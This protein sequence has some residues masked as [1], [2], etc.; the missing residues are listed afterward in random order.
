MNGFTTKSLAP[1]SSAPTM[2]R[3]CLPGGQHHHREIGGGGLLANAAEDF[4]PIDHGHHRVEHHGV[5]LVRGEAFQRLAAVPRRRHLIAPGAQP[6]RQQVDEQL[7]IIAHQVR[8]VITS[9][10]LKGQRRYPL[11]NFD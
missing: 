5:R 7:V 10:I 4:E 11:T 9:P 2:S 8:L 1:S 3:S 6:I